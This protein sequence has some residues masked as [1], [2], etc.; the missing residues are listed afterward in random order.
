MNS[1]SLVGFGVLGYRRSYI[2]IHIYLYKY[3]HSRAGLGGTC[4]RAIEAL[5]CGPDHAC[6]LRQVKRSHDP[7]QA[8]IQEVIHCGPNTLTSLGRGTATTIRRA[9][10]LRRGPSNSLVWPQLTSLGR[11]TATARAATTFRRGP[12]ISCWPEHIHLDWQGHGHAK[13]RSHDPAAGTQQC[14]CFGPNHVTS[15][16]RGTAIPLTR[17]LAHV[18]PCTR[19]LCLEHTEGKS[20]ARTTSRAAPARV[21]ASVEL[22]NPI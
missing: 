15:L 7:D 5:P 4:W 3:I 20:S 22:Q 18:S 1:I 17:P 8:G 9:T 10:T 11:G 16:G 13:K 19:R 21:A 6:A 14:F 12:S 2:N